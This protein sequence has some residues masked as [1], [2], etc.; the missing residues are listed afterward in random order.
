[1]R[2]E[3]T[4]RPLTEHHFHVKDLIET[5]DK[6]AEDRTYHRNK[7]KALEERMNDIKAA[8]PKELKAFWCETCELD[9]LAESFKEVEIDW[10]CPTQYVA[11]YRT[12]CFRGHWCMRLI[13]DVH[14]DAYWFKS[15]RVRADQ[16]EHALDTIQP[17]ET[18]FNLLYGKR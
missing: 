2:Y 8:K 14:K 3:H 16:G 18:N 10:S 15:R 9:F 4:P 12:K 5:Q 6:R 13:T 17:N 11:F 7:A 1:M